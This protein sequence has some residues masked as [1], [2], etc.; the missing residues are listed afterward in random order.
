MKKWHKISL[1]IAL[2]NKDDD[3][4]LKQYLNSFSITLSYLGA[5]I[6]KHFKICRWDISCLTR[7][8]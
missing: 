4:E 1:T 8:N 6:K 7:Q 3:A 2:A 5:L